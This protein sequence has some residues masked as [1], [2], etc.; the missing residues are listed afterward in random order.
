V[1]TVRQI[2]DDP[3]GDQDWAITA[4]VDLAGSDEAG[5]PVVHL[6]AVGPS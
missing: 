6:V 1:W 3:D 4:Q 2:L 5:E